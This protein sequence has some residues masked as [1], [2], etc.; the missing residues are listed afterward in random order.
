MSAI[1][2]PPRQQASVPAAA[3]ITLDTMHAMGATSAREW[4]DDVEGLRDMLVLPAWRAECYADFVKVHE[5]DFDFMEHL[6]AWERGFDSVQP[7]GPTPSEMGLLK[8]YRLSDDRG[9]A[10][11]YDMAVSMAEDWPRPIA[12]GAA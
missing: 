1:T 6:A 3:P 12:G 9:R 2:K 8:A 7:L 11:I 10:S 4:V 5:G